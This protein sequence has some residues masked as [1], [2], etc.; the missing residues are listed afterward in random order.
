MLLWLS[1]PGSSVYSFTPVGVKRYLWWIRRK[2]R[3][4]RAR[5]G[6]VVEI[7]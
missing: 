1:P 7:L 6:K 3:R 4:I 5:G 2:H